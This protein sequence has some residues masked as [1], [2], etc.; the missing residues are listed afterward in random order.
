MITV[1]IVFGVIVLIV[2]V[3]FC[4]LLVVGADMRRRRM[5]P[6]NNVETPDRIVKENVSE[7]SRTPRRQGD[8]L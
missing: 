7:K 6:Q 5:P 8:G 2:A 4:Y 1:L 3:I